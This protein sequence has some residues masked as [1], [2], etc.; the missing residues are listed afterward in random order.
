MPADALEIFEWMANAFAG[1]RYIFS[2][3]FRQRTHARWKVEGRGTAV[4]EILF[5][6]A[7]MLFTLFL[8]W[9]VVDLLRS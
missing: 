5:G 1:W 4:L 7:G 9:L 2:P 6:A 8:L 3:S